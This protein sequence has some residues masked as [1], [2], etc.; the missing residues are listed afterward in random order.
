[1]EVIKDYQEFQKLIESELVCILATTHTC[2]VCHPI[3]I[4]LVDV[5]SAYP[6]VPLHKVFLEDVQ[7]FQGQQLIFTVPTIVFYHEKKEIL[8]ESRFIDFDKIERLLNNFQ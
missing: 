3:E 8:R 7:E 6:N 4:R 2:R 5:M 1:M